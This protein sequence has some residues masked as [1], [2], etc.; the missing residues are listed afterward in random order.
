MDASDDKIVYWHRELPPFDAE[1][2]GEHVVKSDKQS[3]SRKA[4]RHQAQAV[5]ASSLQ[6]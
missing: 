1:A 3:L 5:I 2:M 6:N 4:G